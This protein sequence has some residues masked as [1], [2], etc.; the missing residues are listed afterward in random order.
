VSFTINFHTS[1]PKPSSYS[2]IYM[3]IF[4]YNIL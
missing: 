1:P 3:D 4:T 2:I